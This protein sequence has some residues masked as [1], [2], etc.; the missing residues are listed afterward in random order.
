MTKA[1]GGGGG[2]GSLLEVVPDAREK[3]NKHT[4]VKVFFSGVGTERADLEKGVKMGGKGIQLPMIRV[5]AV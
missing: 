3:T 4:H 2:G 5:L 1:S